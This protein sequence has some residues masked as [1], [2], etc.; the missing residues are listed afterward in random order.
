MNRRMV[1]YTVGHIALAEALVFSDSPSA[2]ANF[3]GDVIICRNYS[4][5][6]PYRPA[7]RIP[8]QVLEDRLELEDCTIICRE[9]ETITQ[10]PNLFTVQPQGTIRIRSR[11]PGDKIRLPGGTKQLKKLLIDRKIPAPQRDR[12]AVICDDLGIL[13]VAGIGVNLDRAAAGLPACQIEICN[14]NSALSCR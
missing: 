6:Q 10:T 12:I 13:A 14:K 11:M 7:P 8:E 5:L 1:F 3:P 9:A 2:R 4:A